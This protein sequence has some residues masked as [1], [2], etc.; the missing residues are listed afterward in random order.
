MI[1]ANLSASGPIAEVTPS[2]LSALGPSEIRNESWTIDTRRGKL[3]HLFIDKTPN[4][5]ERLPGEAF[6]RYS[7]PI[8]GSELRTSYKAIGLSDPRFLFGVRNSCCPIAQ[9]FCKREML[10]RKRHLSPHLSQLLSHE[11]Q[12]Q[13]ESRRGPQIE[14][15]PCSSIEMDRY[16]RVEQNR[17]GQQ[18]K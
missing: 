13:K 11:E 16:K 7:T 12:V 15:E 4:G 3:A 2:A 14:N 8:P 18:E 1:R 6:Q 10:F 17:D 9:Q 5:G